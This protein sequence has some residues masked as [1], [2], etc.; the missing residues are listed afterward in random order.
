MCLCSVSAYI[1]IERDSKGPLS[2]TFDVA[3]AEAAQSRQ[4]A[5]WNRI[6]I[7]VVGVEA[8]NFWQNLADVIKILPHDPWAICPSTVGRFEVAN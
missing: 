8:F 1:S 5:W 7:Q 4:L 3:Q 2:A 6:S